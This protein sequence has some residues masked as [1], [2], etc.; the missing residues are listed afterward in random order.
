M[1][2]GDCE[3]LLSYTFELLNNYDVKTDYYCSSVKDQKSLQKSLCMESI[4][5]R[6]KSQ[7]DKVI[8][9][10]DLV[11]SIHCK[12]IFPKKIVENIKCINFHPGYNPYNRGW[13]PHV[14]SIINKLP[15]GV[16]IHEMDGEIDNGEIIARE[17][18]KINRYDTSKTIYERLLKKEKMILS[19]NMEKILLNKYDKFSVQGGNINYKSDYEKLKRIDLKKSYKG[20]DLFDRLRALSHKPYKNAYF[21]DDSGNKY[22][23]NIEIKK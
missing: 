5:L 2:I 8:K 20:S 7:I 14:F 18:I 17:K 15:A 6:D 10:Y 23:V 1:V 12:Q 21:E 22:F 11:L 16:T 3:E 4:D 13:F 9:N 19:D